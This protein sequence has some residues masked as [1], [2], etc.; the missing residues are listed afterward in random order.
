[1]KFMFSV[2]KDQIHGDLLNLFGQQS[3]PSYCINV[4][5]DMNLYLKIPQIPYPQ[6]YQILSKY[7]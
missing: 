1:M 3:H 2:F 6:T 7:F 5:A 4:Q